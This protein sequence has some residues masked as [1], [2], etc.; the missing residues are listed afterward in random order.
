LVSPETL[1]DHATIVIAATGVRDLIAPA[2]IRPGKIFFALSN[3]E[4]EISARHTL[5]AGATFATDGDILP[6]ILD[7][8][9]PA[10]IAHA[11]S[12]T[13]RADP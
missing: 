3:P 1:I 11:V 7:P 10:A 12:E 2:W 6:G 5:E 4:P 9:T 13:A 8:A